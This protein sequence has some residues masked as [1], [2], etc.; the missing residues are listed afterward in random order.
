MK[1]AFYC[2]VLKPLGLSSVC[3][4]KP[5]GQR[6]PRWPGGLHCHGGEMPQGHGDSAKSF[7][8]WGRGSGLHC[9]LWSNSSHPHTPTHHLFPPPS[10]SSNTCRTQ[11]G[12]TGFFRRC[13]RELASRSPEWTACRAVDLGGPHTT[14]LHHSFLHTVK[15]VFSIKTTACPRVLTQFR[16]YDRDVARV[17][18]HTP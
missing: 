3:W 7:D 16:S 11:S 2:C 10:F 15:M 1:S 17:L 4:Q 12:F 9:A 6:R 14:S 18:V 8:Y 13:R 5:Q